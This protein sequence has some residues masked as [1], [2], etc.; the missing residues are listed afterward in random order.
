M[1]PVIS[2]TIHTVTNAS[3]IHLIAA[4][5]DGI[6]VIFVGSDLSHGGYLHSVYLQFDLKRPMYLREQSLDVYPFRR[7]HLDRTPSSSDIH[8]EALAS[9]V[10]PMV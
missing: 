6:L 1:S 4:Y 10:S 8:C 2:H 7:I 9:Q 3:K 5:I